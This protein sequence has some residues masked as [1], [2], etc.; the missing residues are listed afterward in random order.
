MSTF[1]VIGFHTWHLRV[2]GQF[3]TLCGKDTFNME[4]KDAEIPDE[5]EC[6][7][8][9]RIYHNQRGKLEWQP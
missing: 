9:L 2:K 3:K 7:M 6:K 1:E 5:V 4:L 8:C